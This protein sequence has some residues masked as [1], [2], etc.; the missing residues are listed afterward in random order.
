MKSQK[1]NDDTGVLPEPMAKSPIV[2]ERPIPNGRY[3][4][5][6][7]IPEFRDTREYGLLRAECE[8][9]GRTYVPDFFIG[10]S[11]VPNFNTDEVVEYLSAFMNKLVDKFNDKE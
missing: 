1:M 5:F 9:F 7:Y 4:I 11:I 8:K 3:V 6:Y 2:I 10:L